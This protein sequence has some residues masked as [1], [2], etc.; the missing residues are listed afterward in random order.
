MR[1]TCPVHL[2]RLDLSF[3]ITLGEEYNVC[4]SV[5]CNFVHSPLISFLLA[6]ELQENGENN[7]TELH[8]LY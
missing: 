7:N 3:I 8:A 2:S 6:M 4:S 5:L 1:A